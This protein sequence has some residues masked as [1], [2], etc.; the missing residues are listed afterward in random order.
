MM[1]AGDNHAKMFR[2][3]KMSVTQWNINIFINRKVNLMEKHVNNEV[4]WD[5]ALHKTSFD[6][7]E[8][9]KQ[10]RRQ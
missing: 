9:K 6:G 7:S 8:W 4:T 1:D 5:L 2:N 10:L 3:E